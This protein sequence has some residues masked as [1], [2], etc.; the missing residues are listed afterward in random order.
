M[1]VRCPLDIRVQI[2]LRLKF[3]NEPTHKSSILLLLNSYSWEQL[4]FPHLGDAREKSNIYFLANFRN[5]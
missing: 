2:K 3:L 5:Y 4:G 1:D